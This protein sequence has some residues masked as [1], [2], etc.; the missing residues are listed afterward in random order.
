M[1][2]EWSHQQGVTVCCVVNLLLTNS[3]VKCTLTAYL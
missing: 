3:S 1:V 2:L